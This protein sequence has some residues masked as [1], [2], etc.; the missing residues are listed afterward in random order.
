MIDFSGYTKQAIE[1]AM[2]AQVDPS[3]DTRQGSLI[4]TALG[5]AAW[6]L[7]GLYMTLQQIQQNANADT[8]V[9]ESLDLLVQERGLTRRA[10]TAAVEAALS[11]AHI[12]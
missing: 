9:G 3:L 12:M 10:A 6:Y 11:A 5:P 7:E 8:A 1:E 2:L 4:Q